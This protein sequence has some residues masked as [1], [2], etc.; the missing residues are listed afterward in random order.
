MAAAGDEQ[1][2]LTA[3]FSRA[4]LPGSSEAGVTLKYSFAGLCNDFFT[5]AACNSTAVTASAAAVADGS[6]SNSDE[7]AAAA[8]APS[9]CAT[10]DKS[11]ESVAFI[12]SEATLS[13]LANTHCLIELLQEEH[14]IGTAKLA[15]SNGLQGASETPL[16]VELLDNTS[17]TVVG[18]LDVLLTCND[19]LSD[20]CIGSGL[21]AI[22]GASISTL[23]PQWQL[24]H[25][26]LNGLEGS[27]LL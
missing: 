25:P 23:P 26:D 18:K 17:S 7:A 13:Q 21:L 10:F 2:V 20:Y 14:S 15:L 3:V 27:K 16:T 9:T 12:I 5:A 19:P 1:G 11:V 24:S 22:N 8:A 6:T 4:L